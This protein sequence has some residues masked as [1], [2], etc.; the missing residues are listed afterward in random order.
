MLQTTTY[1]ACTRKTNPPF[2]GN[3]STSKLLGWLAS[4]GRHHSNLSRG[5]VATTPLFLKSK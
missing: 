4:K 5:N 1:G 3:D 2:L